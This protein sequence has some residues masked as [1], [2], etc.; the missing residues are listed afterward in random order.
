MSGVRVG[1][2]PDFI[3]DAVAA[4]VTV[5]PVPRVTGELAPRLLLV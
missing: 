1:F 2:A 3:G 4:F 5:L